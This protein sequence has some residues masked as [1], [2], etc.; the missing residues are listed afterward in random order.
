MKSVK[1]IVAIAAAVAMLGITASPVCAAS[2]VTKEETVYVVTEADGSQNDVIVSDHL[3]N[4]RDADK[5]KDRS[6]LSNIEN[7]KGDETF[8]AGENGSMTW[9]AGGNDIFYEGSTT[10]EVPVQLGISYFLNGKEVQGSEL[11]GASGD[12]K[13]VINYRNTAVD[14][15]GTTIPFV[16]MTGFIAENDTF[17]DIEIDHGKVVDDGD[18]KIVV[19]LAAPGMNDALNINRDLVDIELED[20]VTITGTANNFD[21]QDMMTFVTNSLFDEIDADDFGDLDYDDQIRELDKGAKALMKGSLQLYD[22]I[23]TLY[24]NMPKFAKGADQLEA[25]AN[26]LSAGADKAAK[27]S[28]K[29]SK[30]T[31]QLAGQL[32]SQMSEAVD[33]TAQMQEGAEEILSGLK[34]IRAGLNGTEDQTGA[35]DALEQLANGLKDGS[36]KLQST[37][38]KM[39]NSVAAAN[40]IAQYMSEVNKAVSSNKALLRAAGFGKLV[41]TTPTVNDYAQRLASGLEPVPEDLSQAA[42]KLYKD[43]SSTAAANVATQVAGGLETISGSLGK[44]SEPNT[45][46]GGMAQIS[47]GLTELHD[48]LEKATGKNS[49]LSKGLNQLTSGANQISKGNVKLAGGAKELAKGMGE[50]SEGADQIASGA[51]QLDKG[52]LKLS[53]G[54][55]ELYKK[56]IRKIV[57]LYNDDLK[58]SLDDMNDLLDAGQSYKTFTELE[59]DMDGSVKFIYKTSV[60]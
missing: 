1:K 9:N 27:G 21:I 25:G 39:E 26:K 45:L 12:V 43:G 34:K 31:K 8:D 37:S 17:T 60:Y 38:E 57:D 50:L 15:N 48:T 11:E 29:L 24:Q 47:G 44:T 6:N 49:E 32:T 22:G 51:A 4:D 19:G 53:Q 42:D 55:G 58:G 13:I 30:G 46:I 56:G 52:S 59:G 7:V 18:K 28:K 2:K 23:D 40:A 20:S 14:E 41:D 16:A 36:S 5:I 35:I 33:G 10:E 3:K 54:M